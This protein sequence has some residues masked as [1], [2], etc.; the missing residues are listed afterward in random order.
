MRR[1][2]EQLKDLFLL[3]VI[4]EFNSGK[5]SF[6]NAILGDKF[7]TEGVTPTTSQVN[8]LRYGDKKGSRT[9]TNTLG[10]LKKVQNALQS[11][12]VEFLNGH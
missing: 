8:I 2:I 1:S 10:E 6:L 4:G 7:L 9:V 12:T 5:S 11:L 3:V